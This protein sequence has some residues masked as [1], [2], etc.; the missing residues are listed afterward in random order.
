MIS[1]VVVGT[2]TGVGTIV[3]S[4]FGYRSPPE[5]SPPPVSTGSGDADD[6]DVLCGTFDDAEALLLI[7]GDGETDGR[8][9]IDGVAEM[10]LL[11]EGN[12]EDEGDGIADIDEVAEALLLIDAD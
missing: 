12:T 3:D 5:E 11:S 8:A 7:V 9:D 10:L 1:I 4:Q 6:G 2:S